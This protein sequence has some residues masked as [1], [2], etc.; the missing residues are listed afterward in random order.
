M[1]VSEEIAY[2]IQVSKEYMYS[3]IAACICLSKNL[4]W[5]IHY[6]GKQSSLAC[7]WNNLKCDGIVQE[8]DVSMLLMFLANNIGGSSPLLS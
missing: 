2:R 1:A 3:I 5:E 8:T 4:F 6:L 7:L